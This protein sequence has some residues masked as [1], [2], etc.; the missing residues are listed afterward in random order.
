MANQSQWKAVLDFLSEGVVLLD[1][2]GRV[3][4]A[5]RA[6]RRMLGEGLASLHPRSW[7]SG[8]G[9]FVA[10]GS[11]PAA[12]SALP[13][14][15]VLAGSPACEREFSVRRA[16]LSGELR[17]RMRAFPQEGGGVLCLVQDLT[18]SRLREQTLSRSLAQAEETLRKFIRG[19]EQSPAC[20]VI[21]DVEGRI[22]YVNPK[23]TELTGYAP[24]EVYGQNPRILKSGHTPPEQYRQLWETILAG[25]QWSG[26]FLNR[27]KNGELYWELA[28]I[29]P[30]QS[31][32]GDIT[33]F[34]AVKE[35]ITE[36]KRFE[37]EIRQAHDRLRAVIETSPLAI[38]T[39][40][41]EG[42]VTS[43]NGA[44][45]RISGWSAE[46]VLGQVLPVVTEDFSR[47]F[48]TRFEEAARGRSFASLQGSG[49]RKDGRRLEM[50]VWG[51]PLPQAEARNSVLLLFADI[52]ER[53]WLEGELRQ[54]QKM[55]ALGRLAGGVAHDFNNLLT[56]ISG[57]GE[58]LLTQVPEPLREDVRAI[59]EGAERATTLT[60]Q[61]LAL[62]RRQAGRPRVVDL[63]TVIRGMEQII[64]R[65]L[66]EGVTLELL[67]RA[68]LWPVK[69]DPGQLEQIL[70][71]LAVNARDAMPRGGRLVVATANC[72][73]TEAAALHLPP[74]QYVRLTVRD[75]GEG[76]DPETCQ[77]IFEPFF[78]TKSTDKGTGLGLAIVYG[79]VKQS[80]GEVFV[81]SRLGEGTIFTIYLPRSSGIPA[82]RAAL[83]A[84]PPRAEGGESILL[85]EDED[86][87]RHL[88]RNVLVRHGYVVLD[89]PGG[90]QA[91]EMF[92]RHADRVALLL[93]DVV[94]PGMSGRELAARLRARRPELKVV[95]MSGYPGDV[96]GDRG[97]PEPGMTLIQKPFTP[98]TLLRRLREVLAKPSGTP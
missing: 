84:P 91:L 7:A 19:V 20:V 52:T 48:W 50:E 93:T 23:F 79:I 36:R 72:T 81:D 60:R 75:T 41:A 65:A 37:R 76:L 88:V 11:T 28:L 85:V 49:R 59:L 61:L 54:A 43:W 22:E 95:Y 69:A 15:A 4:E 9:L 89:A 13:A 70:L 96:L 18:E 42:R 73:R 3:V 29:S 17:I 51:V 67:L 5:N 92:E 8:C 27:K 63:N 77:R 80:G 35:D 31:S 32:A 33:H 39:L 86:A 68:S 40:D 66:G 94:M 47:V 64:R 57:Y 55:E 34:I 10:E 46:E 56:I 74:G 30:V 83:A 25:G 14:E 71:N 87:V 16:D 98:R 12:A 78:S 90:E 1:A 45:Q 82:S 6:A 44:A 2:A 38:C 24:E 58:L 26:E 53:K 21:T 62:S 97:I